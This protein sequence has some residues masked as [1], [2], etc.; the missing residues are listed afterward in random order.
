MGVP[1]WTA[2]SGFDLLALTYLVRSPAPRPAA[3]ARSRPGRRGGQDRAPGGR[4][5]SQ[6]QLQRRYRRPGIRRSIRTT[7][8]AATSASRFAQL[9][10]RPRPTTWTSSINPAAFSPSRTSSTRGR[11]RSG[12]GGARLGVVRRAGASTSTTLAADRPGPG[13]AARPLGALGRASASGMPS[14]ASA[15]AG[16]LR[17]A[18]RGQ[19]RRRRRRCRS[20]TLTRVGQVGPS[21]VAEVG[22]RGAS[23]RYRSAPPRR[24][25][26][27]QLASAAAAESASDAPSRP[28]SQCQRPK[29][30]D[31]GTQLAVQVGR[32]SPRGARRPAHGEYGLDQ[33][34]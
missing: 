22:R 12:P 16:R 8:Q 31:Q 18:R 6:V 13:A 33:L 24:H 3:R 19:D 21:S 32:R 27:R 28:V 23:R 7:I 25:G 17:A 2:G 5:S 26:Q 15:E 11:R 14:P 1:A 10:H 30:L 20:S 34:G 9:H 4:V 29:P